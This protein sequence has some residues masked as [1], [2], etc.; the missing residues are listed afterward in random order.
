MI[1]RAILTAVPT[2]CLLAILTPAGASA[3]GGAYVRQATTVAG[4]A[5]VTQAA[6]VARP[7]RQVRQTPAPVAPPIQPAPVSDKTTI[8]EFPLAIT[9]GVVTLPRAHISAP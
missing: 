2:A 1:E 5:T 4:M 3:D 8:L 7:V 9:K 6:D